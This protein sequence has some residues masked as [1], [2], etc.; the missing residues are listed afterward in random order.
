MKH[1]RGFGKR[2]FSLSII[3]MYSTLFKLCKV[4]NNF[5]YHIKAF[6]YTQQAQAPPYSLNL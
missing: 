5:Q 4:D 1:L 6:E 2:Y 3:A